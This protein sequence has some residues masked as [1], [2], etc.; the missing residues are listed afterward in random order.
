MISTETAEKQARILICDPNT[1]AAENLAAYLQQ[2][3]YRIRCVEESGEAVNVIVSQWPDLVILDTR[4]PVAG[5]FEVCRLVRSS[6]KGR[7]IFQS[8]NNGEETQLLA[9]EMG[10]DDYIF[11]PI[12]PLLMAARLRAHLKQ[13]NEQDTAPLDNQIRIGDL[14]VD[15]ASREVHMAGRLVSLTTV[16]FDLLWYLANRPGRVVS[17]REIYEDLYRAEYN[18]FDRSIDMYVSRIRQQLGDHVENPRFLKT[19]RGVEYLFVSRDA[20]EL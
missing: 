16:Q 6:Y 4:M 12:S 13:G 5:G 11:K 14:V 2:I 3:G 7:I 15:A 20:V 18:G 8:R 19:V 17:R 1:K 10:A 9:F